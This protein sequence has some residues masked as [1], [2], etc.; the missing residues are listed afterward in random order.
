[1]KTTKPIWILC[2]YQEPTGQLCFDWLLWH[3]LPSERA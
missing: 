1:M 2:F 3:P